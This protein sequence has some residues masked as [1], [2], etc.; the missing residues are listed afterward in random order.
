MVRV[1]IIKMID[2]NSNKA[3]PV[4]NLQSVVSFTFSNLATPVSV[5]CP[6][7]LTPQTPGFLMCSPQT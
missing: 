7:Y 6:L 3:R 4:L 1:R 2:T 5:L